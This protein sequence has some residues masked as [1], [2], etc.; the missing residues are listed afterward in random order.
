[1]LRQMEENVTLFKCLSVRINIFP[2]HCSSLCSSIT[3]ISF[4]A[5]QNVKAFN[6]YKTFVKHSIS[7][8]IIQLF[9]VFHTLTPQVTFI[10][11][12]WPGRYPRIYET[13]KIQF[14][15]K[16]RDFQY[17]LLFFFFHLKFV[18]FFV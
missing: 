10:G 18:M 9:N 5:R 12:P 14:R 4:A 6:G 17:F 13:F 15:T 8:D 7:S 1:M 3:C 16:S 11:L 2:L